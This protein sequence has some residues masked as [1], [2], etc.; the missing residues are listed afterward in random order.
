M[1]EVAV[2]DFGGD[3]GREGGE[4]R[5]LVEGGVGTSG[6]HKNVYSIF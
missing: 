2:D 5:G 1:V 6:A 4:G 3:A